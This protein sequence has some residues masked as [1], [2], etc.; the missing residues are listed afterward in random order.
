MMRNRTIN[1]AKS[2]ARPEDIKGTIGVSDRFADPKL[3]EAIEEQLNSEQPT[4]SSQE[5]AAMTPSEA[6]EEASRSKRDVDTVLTEIAGTAGRFMR[7]PRAKLLPTPAEWNPFSQVSQEK[8]VLMA[9]SIYRT[10]LQQPIVVRS[11]DEDGSAY[12]ILAGNTR[13]EIFGILY[14]LTGD[15]K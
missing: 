5:K 1:F 2:D 9:D 12:Q 14:E 11:M 15:E 8:K 4:A 10:G 7:I 3:K 13:T 6:A